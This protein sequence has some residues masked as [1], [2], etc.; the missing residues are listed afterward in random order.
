[1]T[2]VKEF[3]RRSWKW[4][5]VAGAVTLA[6]VASIFRPRLPGPV[7]PTPRK[8]EE[9]VHRSEVAARQ[10][11]AAQQAAQEAATTAAATNRA[12][13]ALNQLERDLAARSMDASKDAGSANDYADLVRPR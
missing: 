12:A 3:L 6:I 10:E 4:L 7:M 9:D 13:G 11:A 1:M 5:L 8:P 2:K